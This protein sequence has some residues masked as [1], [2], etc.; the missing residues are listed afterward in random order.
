M[1]EITEPPKDHDFIQTLEDFFF[2]VIGYTHPQ[3]RI[4]A[5]LKYIPSQ[6]GKWKLEKMPLKR[7]LSHYSALEVLQ[8]YKYL[9]KNYQKYFFNC[10]ISKI[11]IT[12]VPY[13]S[14]KKYYRPQDKINSLYA[15]CGENKLDTLQKKVIELIAYLGSFSKI[16][17]SNFG[18][19]G[20]ILTDTHNIAF[21]DIDL[22]IHGRKNSQIIEKT[23]TELFNQENDE[24]SRLQF[25][26]AEE[27]R[28]NK[29]KIFNL[30]EEQSNL[31]YER[32][33]NMGLFKGTRFSIHPIRNDKEILE[34][35]G[36]LEFF[37]EGII[38]IEGTVRQDKDS[39]FLPCIY[40]IFDV[41]IKN[42]QKIE[43]ITQICSYEGLYSFILKKGERFRARGKL[44]K[45]VDKKRN[46]TF[47]RLLI[48]SFLA[49]SQ[50]FLL[51]LI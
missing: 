49:K 38:E 28:R 14:I 15:L 31:L 3:N 17:N 11:R 41:K 27:W 33:W 7:V 40:E 16:D 18:V 9:E 34:K 4:I 35:Y 10:P 8:S 12:A 24:I 44:E 13:N 19:T 23:I 42:G 20:S 39:I 26:E 36:D 51:P 50:D 47:H 6:N 37:P 22:T 48:G 29:M 2:C 21:S 25:K 46:K 45:V 1:S 32:K 30:N 5:Y 43:G